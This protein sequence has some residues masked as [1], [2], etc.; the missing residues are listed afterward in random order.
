M[1]Y[2]F[3]IDKTLI[4][5]SSDE[6]VDWDAVPLSYVKK[7][8][9]RCDED[10]VE[11]MQSLIK[12]WI[13]ILTGR[14]ERWTDFTKKQLHDFGVPYSKLY[15]RPADLTSVQHKQKVLKTY[16]TFSLFEDEVYP[17]LSHKLVYQP[18]I[19]KIK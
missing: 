4:H 14:H 18:A 12:N 7:V 13:V 11:Y 8:D 16:K 2:I 19:F 6:K 17:I 10:L 1:K 3:D 5:C 9:W 15:M